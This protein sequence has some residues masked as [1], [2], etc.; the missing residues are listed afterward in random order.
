MRPA[1]FKSPLSDDEQNCLSYYVLSGC[2][3]EDAFVAFVNPAL[4]VSAGTLKKV[5]DQF[6][7]GKD[8]KEYIEAYTQ[9]IDAVMHPAPKPKSEKTAEERKKDQEKAVQKL[10]DYVIE[11]AEIIDQ[12]EEPES[13]LKFAEKLGLLGDNEEQVEQPRRYLPVSCVSECRYRT[14]CEE[15]CEDECLRCKYR[16][17]A[18]QNGIHYEP[19]H[20]L[21]SINN[22]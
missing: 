10:V 22:G 17:Y 1:A 13:I 3:R 15:N 5:S 7:A 2:K 12:L 19:E 6:F 14:F 18:E 9:T 20:Q 8:A 16:D 11:K 21:K 4:K